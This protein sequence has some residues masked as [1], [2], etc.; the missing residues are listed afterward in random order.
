MLASR[1]IVHTSITLWTILIG[2]YPVCGFSGSSNLL[3]IYSLLCRGKQ[4]YPA[5]PRLRHRYGPDR[6]KIRVT[7]VASAA[8]RRYRSSSWLISC[9]HPLCS[10]YSGNPPLG[11]S[12]SIANHSDSLAPIRGALGSRWHAGSP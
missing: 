2:S 7:R 1:A 3:G 8:S 12:L 10:I 9:H 11:T 6:T 4:Q 5:N